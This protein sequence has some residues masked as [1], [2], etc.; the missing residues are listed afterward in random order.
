MFGL[1]HRDGKR[2]ANWPGILLTLALHLAALYALSLNHHS[3]Q[4]KDLAPPLAMQW[5][6]LAPIAPKPLTTNA[7]RASTVPA[8]TTSHP[9]AIANKV[10]ATV[11]PSALASA[12][13]APVVSP[14]DSGTGSSLN[15]NQLLQNVKGDIA[16]LDRE[17]HKNHPEPKGVPID[18]VQSKLEKAFASAAAPPKWYEGARTEEITSADDAESGDRKYRIRTAFGSYCVTYPGDGSRYTVYLCR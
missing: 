7:L 15:L 2:T 13:A 3:V 12:L 4:R 10:A 5:I 16:T 17:Q 18:S 8:I 9:I 6:W 1:A 14:T 11:V